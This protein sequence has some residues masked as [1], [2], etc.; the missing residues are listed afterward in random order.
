MDSVKKFYKNYNFKVFN[1]FL[2]WA[3]L[4]NL[5]LD[6]SNL[7]LTEKLKAQQILMFKY[8]ET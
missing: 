1:D 3:K 6:K 2:Y 4:K 8:L 5:L 7:L